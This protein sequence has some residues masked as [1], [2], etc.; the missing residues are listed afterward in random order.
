MAMRPAQITPC[1]GA[2]NLRW[3]SGGWA[4]SVLGMSLWMVLAAGFALAQSEW[5]ASAWLAVCGAGVVSV[6]M[7]LWRSRD[8][9]APLPAALI[10]VSVSFIA[11]IAAIRLLDSVPNV[12]SIQGGLANHTWWVSIYP[13][14]ALLMVFV[15]RKRRP[16]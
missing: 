6:G 3:N 5:T 15:D 7:V 13:A 1:E 16:S 12:A 8:R 11:A 14:M 10:L 9:I 2:G 4:G